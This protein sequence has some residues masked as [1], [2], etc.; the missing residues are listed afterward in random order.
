M[1]RFSQISAVVAMTSTVC[2]ISGPAA[3][4]S[5][6]GSI[7]SG[8][9]GWESNNWQDELYSQITAYGCERRTGGVAAPASVDLQIWEN[10]SFQP[11]ESYDNKT[12][13]AC[14]FGGRSNGEW[15]D[16]PAGKKPYYFQ[17]MKIAGSGGG[18]YV[19][20]IDKYIVDQT[21]AD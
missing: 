6:S 3:Q 2:L 19:V 7:S 15:R 13:T 14:F 16:L 21:L 5:W 17:I 20:D 1:K 18:A 9:V 10:I 11:D 8:R 12:Y 4:A